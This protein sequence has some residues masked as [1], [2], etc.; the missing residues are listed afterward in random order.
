MRTRTS[1]FTAAIVLAGLAAVGMADSTTAWRHC[2]SGT[3]YRQVGHRPT[4][5]DTWTVNHVLSPHGRWLHHRQHGRVWRPRVADRDHS[6]RPSDHHWRSTCAWSWI[7]LN[8]GRWVNTIRCGWVWVPGETCR[9]VSVNY[10]RRH[11]ESRRIFVAPRALAPPRPV[12]HRPGWVKPPKPFR[13]PRPPAVHR[14]SK[15]FRPSAHVVPLPHEKQARLWHSV[16]PVKH[17][18]V[19]AFPIKPGRRHAGYSGFPF[20]CK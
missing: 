20:H 12:F 5:L 15:S 17:A 8:Y 2:P 13:T 18:P 11:H 7:P 19:K 10:A 6:W 9:R 14:P 3:G 16:P 4:V 1:V